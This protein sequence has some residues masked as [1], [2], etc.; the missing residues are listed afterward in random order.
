MP[1]RFA[2]QVHKTAGRLLQAKHIREAPAWYDVVLQHPPIPLPPRAPSN[3]VS[4]DIVTTASKET[5]R[6]MG[7]PNVKPLPIYYLE[8]EIRRQFF[9]DH[10]FEAFRPRSLSEKGEIDDEH[11]IRGLDWT[12]LR[13]RGLNPTPEECVTL[14]FTPNST[15]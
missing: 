5:P 3:R 13:D 8:D 4:Y 7:A 6:R 11:P 10:P 1:R 2:A 14:Y 15:R 9:R 12:R